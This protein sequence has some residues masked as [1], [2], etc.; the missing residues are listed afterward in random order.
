VWRYR[1]SLADGKWGFGTVAG[2]GGVWRKRWRC[3]VREGHSTG[4][5]R[6]AALPRSERAESRF[7][8]L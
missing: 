7:A 6:F 8:C 1:I 4:R 2:A 3:D 5:T